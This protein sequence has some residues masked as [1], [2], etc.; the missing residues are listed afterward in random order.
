[1]SAEELLEVQDSQVLALVQGQQLAQSSIGLDGLLVHQVVALGIGQH[2][3]GYSGAADLSTLGLAQE[4]AQLLSNLHGLSEDAGADLGLTTLSGISLALLATVSLLD[5]TGSLLLNGLQSI[6][7][8]GCGGLQVRQLLLEVGNGLL[9]SGTD[10]LLM[11]LSGSSGGNGR[12]GYCG[13]SGDGLIVLLGGSLGSSGNRGGDGY[14]GCCGDGL[15]LGCGGLLGGLHGG[16]H[17]GVV[18]GTI[19]RHGTRMLHRGQGAN[20]LS[21]LAAGTPKVAGCA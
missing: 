17:F 3:L 19:R 7:C 5:D 8:G 1:V 21:T 18:R 14:S 11:G 15:V 12:H 4:G 2:T 6:G 9:E 16:A 20:E 10:V 13:S